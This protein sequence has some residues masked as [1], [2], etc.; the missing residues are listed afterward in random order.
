[1]ERP[2]KSKKSKKARKAVTETSAILKEAAVSA[3]DAFDMK[4]LVDVA[5]SLE[6]M[7]IDTGSPLENVNDPKI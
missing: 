1:M 6:R 2:S 4:T 7:Q 3:I 5:A